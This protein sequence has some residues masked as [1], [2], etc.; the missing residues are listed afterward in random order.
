MTGDIIVIKPQPQYNLNDVITFKEGADRIV[1]HRIIDI[2]QKSGTPEIATKG[3]A[4]RSL[5][6]DK[7]T[8]S[9]IVGK[10]QFVVPKIGFLVAFTHTTPGLVVMIIIPVILLVM[11]QFVQMSM[12]QNRT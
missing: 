1:T 8:Q 2:A 7:I 10:V 5:D 11:D 6:N 4:N 3:D 12:R 9:N